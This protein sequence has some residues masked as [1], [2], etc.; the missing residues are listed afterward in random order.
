MI[1]KWLALVALVAWGCSTV[2]VETAEP[3]EVL[4]ERQYD[5]LDYGEPTT[6]DF[7]T[8]RVG[9]ALGFMYAWKQPA[10]VAYRLTPDEA[11]SRSARRTNKFTTDV[12]VPGSATPSDYF[13]SG[14]DR[15][16]FAPAAD[17]AW[18][19][20]A[21]AESFYMS[22]MSPQRPGFNRGIWCDLEGHVRRIA[23]EGD[24]LFIYAGPVFLMSSHTNS[25]GKSGVLVPSAFYKV[26]CNENPTNASM[27]AFL[28]PNMGTNAPLSE[29]AMPVDELERTLDMDFFREMPKERQEEL[30]AKLELWKWRL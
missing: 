20:D 24:P 16:H 7:T 10:W 8:N 22:N 9:Y 27:V 21:M 6:T 19:V 28:I 12:G 1:R 5:N 13:H 14:Y 11:S 23:S 2:D 15:G 4:R 29:F 26:V 17:M 3:R 18:D 30:E 25:I